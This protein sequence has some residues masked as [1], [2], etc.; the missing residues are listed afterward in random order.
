MT[1]LSFKLAL[2]ATLSAVGQA[3]W[4]D[5]VFGAK[6]K[7]SYVVLDSR[8][9]MLKGGIGGDII[10][11]TD[12][13]IYSTSTVTVLKDDFCSYDDAVLYIDGEVVNA[14]QVTKVN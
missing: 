12:G 8:T 2:A 1:N 6:D 10:I 7:T 13:Y 11:K 14:R 4:A 5:C 3:A 9:I